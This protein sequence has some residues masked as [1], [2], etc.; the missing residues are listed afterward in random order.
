MLSSLNN[1]DAFKAQCLC[2]DFTE[3]GPCFILGQYTFSLFVCL[4]LY[5]L[6][7]PEWQNILN[8]SHYVAVAQETEIIAMIIIIKKKNMTKWYGRHSPGGLVY[9]CIVTLE[10][11]KKKLFLSWSIFTTFCTNG[12]ILCVCSHNHYY[13]MYLYIAGFCKHVC[14]T[15]KKNIYMCLMVMLPIRHLNINIKH[16][17]TN[18]HREISC[19]QCSESSPRELMRTEAA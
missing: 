8:V 11:K 2:Y 3:N 18:S 7:V 1:G 5:I 16:Q 17:S 12:T 13:S 6:A 14:K 15:K 4:F 19:S 9:C 10:E